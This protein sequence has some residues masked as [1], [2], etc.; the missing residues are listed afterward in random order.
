VVQS[1]LGLLAFPL[2]AW[3]LSEDRRRVPVRVVVVGLSLQIALA[4]LL[5]GV[6][7]FSQIFS[8][9]NRVAL[10]IEEATRA[11]TAVVFGFLG[12]DPIPYEETVPG[13][14]F[15]LAFRGLPIV[16]VMS[17][18]SALLFYWRVLPVVVRAFSRVLERTFG[19]GGAEGLGVS[20][21]IFVGMVEAPL[22]VRPYL[23][24]MTRS[25]VFALMTAGMATIA[26]TVMVLYATIVGGVIPDAMGHI[27]AASVLSAP[28]SVLIAKLMIPE[29][30]RVTRGELAAAS[31]ATS[32]M[33]AITKG[34]VQGIELLL[35]IVGMIIV[36][37][38]L[39]HLVDIL[40]RLL[41]HVAGSELT[42][43]RMLGWVMAPV[44]WLVGVPA[45]ECDT[46][47]SLLGTK[48]VLNE[49]LAYLDMAKL[50]AGE[51]SERTRIIL[52]YALCGFAN[53]GSLGIMIG[54]MGAMAPARRTEIVALGVRS[55]V[56]GTLAA[57]MTGAVAGVFIR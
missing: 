18:L 49:F 43:Q 31:D 53:P 40:L 34:T 38:A 2:F 55:I 4:A 41:P 33:D 14:T 48:T 8:A 51:L 28:A 25:E 19:I 30:G 46:A 45:P 12:G 20:A 6:P 22:L 56:A 27:L 54:G 9:L 15:V 35:Q 5:L 11:G 47:G 39:V 17:A 57:C 1:L 7:F 24:S 3:A 52:L 16:L 50:P 37:V 36:L 13:S 32:S 23:P 10:G 44:A 21:N 42:L 29:T 26:G